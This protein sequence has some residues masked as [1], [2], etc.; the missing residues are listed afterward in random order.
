VS[1][2]WQ[3][4]ALTGRAGRGFGGAQRRALSVQLPSECSR[5]KGPLRI[6]L[7][8]G[9]PFAESLFCPATDTDWV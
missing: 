2:L 1:N 6:K 7:G 5:R 9:E 8:S 4:R 3:L